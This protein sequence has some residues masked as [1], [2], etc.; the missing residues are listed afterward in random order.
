MRLID[1]DALRAEYQAIL[2][3]GDMFCEYDIIGMV[4]NAPTIEY[5]EQITI[6]CDTEEAKQQLLSAFRNAKL[7]ILVEEDRPHGKWI[8]ETDEHLKGMYRCSVCGRRVED[9]TD[10]VKIHAGWEDCTVADIYP[11]CHCGADMREE[12]SDE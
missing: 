2:D 3:R 9:L 1:A 4:D 7:N 10:D 6:K 12:T 5:P 8:E 11:F